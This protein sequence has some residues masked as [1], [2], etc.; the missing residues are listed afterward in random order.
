MN[1]LLNSPSS[2]NPQ[3]SLKSN[4]HVVIAPL[5]AV[6]LAKEGLS[7]KAFATVEAFIRLRRIELV[8][9]LDGPLRLANRGELGGQ[10][11]CKNNYFEF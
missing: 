10:S 7:A 8:A 5:S 1:S 9:S 6:A 4:P 2:P 11:G 3:I